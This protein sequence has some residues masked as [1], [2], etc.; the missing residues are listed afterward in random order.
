MSVSVVNEHSLLGHLVCHGSDGWLAGTN[1]GM[2]TV[3]K[4]TLVS[5]VVR[6]GSS[7]GQSLSSSFLSPLC[8]EL[9]ISCQ[10]WEL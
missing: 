3:W 4:S 8:S 7:Q 2:V 6:S 10:L 1:A 5:T 9:H